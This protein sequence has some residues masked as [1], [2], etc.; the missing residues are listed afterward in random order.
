MPS[1]DGRGAA[2]SLTARM[3]RAA[4]APSLPPERDPIPGGTDVSRLLGHVAALRERAPLAGGIRGRASQLI[5]RVLGRPADLDAELI[6]AIDALT[7]AV[8]SL[9]HLSASQSTRLAEHDERLTGAEARQPP[10]PGRP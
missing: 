6:D 7:E 4:A 10:S 2:G 5:H 3:E 8:L 9:N 1:M